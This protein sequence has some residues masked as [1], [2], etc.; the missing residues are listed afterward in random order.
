VVV[1]GWRDV[2]VTAPA[3]LIGES[4]VVGEVGGVA[5]E[6]VVAGG[7][8]VGGG[9]VA[10]VVEGLGVVVTGGEAVIFDVPTTMTSL[11][12]PAATD[13]ELTKASPV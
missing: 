2:V 13:V 6:E 4:V 1:T 12:A 11:S 10:V 9:E 7:A 5:V 8:R 3:N